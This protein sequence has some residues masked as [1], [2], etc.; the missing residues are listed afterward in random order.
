VKNGREKGSSSRNVEKLSGRFLFLAFLAICASVFALYQ[1][2]DSSPPEFL[3]SE[4][5]PKRFIDLDEP[6][7]TAERENNDN[8][9][10]NSSLRIAIAPV[11]SPEKSIQIY[12]GLLDYIAVKIG[13]K[14]LLLQR[15]TYGETND[16][17][18][19]GRCDLALVCTYAFVRGEQEFGMEVFVVPVIDGAI[20][21]QSF[22]LVPASSRASSLLD[23]RGKRFASADIMSTSGW[24]F[25]AIWLMGKGMDANTFFSE[26]AVVG[27]HDRSIDAVLSGYVD[28]AAV[29]S[30]VYEHMRNENASI[31]EKTRIIQKSPP[32]GMP[33]FVVSPQI[34]P[35]LKERLLSILVKMHEDTAGRE[36][37]LSLNIDRFVVP[38]ETLYDDVREAVLIWESRQ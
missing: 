4:L 20:T 29:D 14:P 8:I 5:T 3:G 34:D 21:Y 38:A 19:Y 16:L 15:N 7:P 11:I 22:I 37:L 35:V 36:V 32:Y 26:H 12:Q 13:R 18:R 2:V 24:L 31:Q 6:T 33:P 23:L 27:S 9:S 30:I 17:V 1:L 25:P 28:G 10:D